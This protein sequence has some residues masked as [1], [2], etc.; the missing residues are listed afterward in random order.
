MNFKLPYSKAIIP[1][2]GARQQIPRR[3][4]VVAIPP[5]PRSFPIRTAF[6][7]L[8]V[9]KSRNSWKDYLWTMQ[10]IR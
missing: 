10:S 5:E 4:E 2:T 9:C 3:K 7:L 6:E 8:G 1:S